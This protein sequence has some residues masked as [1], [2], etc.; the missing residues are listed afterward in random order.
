MTSTYT[1]AISKVRS[2]PVDHPSHYNTHPAGVECIDVVEHMTFNLGNAVK[3]LWRA[4]LKGN[5]VEDL[6]K[7]IWYINREIE[8]YQKEA[9]KA[10]STETLAGRLETLAERLQVNAPTIPKR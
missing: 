2:D 4:G 10:R 1:Y 7:A 9:I 8:R 3:Y 6:R 5:T